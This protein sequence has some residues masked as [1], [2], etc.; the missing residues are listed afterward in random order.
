YGTEGCS[1]EGPTLSVRLCEPIT[2]RQEPQ[3]ED[4]SVTTRTVIERKAC[5]DTD[6]DGQPDVTYSEL[7]EVGGNQPP[8]LIGTYTAA[9]LSVEYDPT[10]PVP[11]LEPEPITC[12]MPPDDVTSGSA[13]SGEPG[14]L[15]VVDNTGAIHWTCAHLS[16]DGGGQTLWD[17]QPLQFG[18]DP[19]GQDE[20][21]SGVR[22]LY[23]DISAQLIAARPSC[24]DGTAQITVSVHVELQGDNPAGYTYFGGLRLYNARTE[25]WFASDLVTSPDPQHLQPG[26]QETL[27]L[28]AQVLAQDLADGNIYTYLA[29]ETW[30]DIPGGSGQFAPTEWTASDF[31]ASYS[32]NTEGCVDELPLVAVKVCEPITTRYQIEPAGGAPL[33]T[34]GG[35]VPV[36]RWDDTDNDGRPDTPFTEVWQMVPG[37]P[38]RLVDTYRSQPGDG[39]LPINPGAP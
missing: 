12:G 5:D 13:N 20:C 29:L 28:Q 6:G 33:P 27:H 4:L 26:H 16:R 8:T 37:Q 23:R 11:C 32:Y 31:Q 25:E 15:Q 10:N 24:D 7:W 38:P 3:A 14:E 36:Q 35:L 30:E 2:I 1:E 34:T 39:Y 22:Y 9:D 21:E 17:G 19:D 18:P